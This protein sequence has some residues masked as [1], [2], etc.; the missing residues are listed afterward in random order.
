MQRQFIDGDR[1]RHQKPF[2]M[3]FICATVAALSRYWINLLL[4]RFY[5][6]GDMGE[7]HFFHQY[8]V[9]L[10]IALLPL[11]SF[12]TFLFFRNS[13]YNYGELV[14]LM[15]YTVSF[16]FLTVSAI[17][18]LKFIWPDLNTAFVELPL[19]S[20]Y[21]VI[22]FVRFFNRQQRWIVALKSILV[23]L[24]LFLSAHYVEKL[25]IQML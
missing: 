2:S 6:A 8:M 4:L 1:A 13:R 7:A 3:F 23:L 22:T 24:I 18:L 25:F 20:I 5:G 12:M 15:L 21:N 14:V 11:Y 9:M 10:H 17:A 16:F 19:L